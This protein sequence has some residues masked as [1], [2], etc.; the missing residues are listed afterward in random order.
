MA[1]RLSVQ[2]Q[3]AL[4]KAWHAWLAG[5]FLVAY[6][7]A[8]EDSYAMHQ[9]AGYAG[10]AAIALRLAA[11]LL[12]RPACRGRAGRRRARGW[13]RARAATRSLPGSALPCSP[14]SGWRP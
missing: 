10:L 6:L 2:L 3:L 8:D 5:G 11:G 4:L 1:G 7:T 12:I 13:P 14:P 9:F